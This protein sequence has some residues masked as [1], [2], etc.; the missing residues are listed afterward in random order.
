MSNNL[1]ATKPLT[2]VKAAA[3]FGIVF[4]LI[5]IVEFIVAYA[6]DIDPM[7]NKWAGVINSLLN[8]LILPVL[9]ILLAC[10]TF[11]KANN[12]YIKL[13]QAIKTGVATA[14]LAAIIFAVFSIAFN[15]I[16]PEAQ[17]E[18]MEKMKRAQLTANPDMTAEQLKMTMKFMEVFMKPYITFPFTIMFYAFIGLIYS[19]IVGA[20]IKKENPYGDIN[21]SQINN[22][23]TEE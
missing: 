10:N 14:V 16:F 21:P 5:M 4:G 15:L 17:A 3:S 7:E 22:I 19:L 1:T 12:G 6:I 18:M 11:K 23:G 9:F 13:P 8:N 2:P 20:I